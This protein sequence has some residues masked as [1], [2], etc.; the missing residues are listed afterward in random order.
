[1]TTGTKPKS[2]AGEELETKIAKT[3]KQLIY[4]FLVGRGRWTTV[5]RTPRNQEVVGSNPAGCW[6]FFLLLFLPTFLHQWSVLNQV[7]QGGASL[8][9]CCESNKN[10]CLAVLSGAKQTQ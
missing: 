2:F 6:A 8:T 9:L 10:R 4:D 1:M 5:K 7:T 3:I